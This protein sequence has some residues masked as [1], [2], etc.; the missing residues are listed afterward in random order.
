MKKL[1]ILSVLSVLFVNCTANEIETTESD[2]YS[3]KVFNSGGSPKV[4]ITS[5]CN[6]TSQSGG[7]VNLYAKKGTT[8]TAQGL[9]YHIDNSNNYGAPDVDEVANITIIVNDVI[10]KEGKDLV[11]YT[12]Q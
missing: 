2:V 8:I 11:S 1:F 10:V 12:I 9:S 5:D 7:S 6:T 4:Y 3:V